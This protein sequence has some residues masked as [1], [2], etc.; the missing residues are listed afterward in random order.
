MTEVVVT[1]VAGEP[2]PPITPQ[3]G[4]ATGA[5]TAPGPG[6]ATELGTAGRPLSQLPLTQAQLIIRSG[7]VRLLLGQVRSLSGRV[8]SGHVISCHIITRSC[9]IVTM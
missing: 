7:Q 5:H 1:G 4:P 2:R 3:P 8:R 6:A 9:L